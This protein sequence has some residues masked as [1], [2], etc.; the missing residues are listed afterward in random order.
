MDSTR[1]LAHIKLHLRERKSRWLSVGIGFGTSELRNLRFSLDWE[2]RN[3]F[4]TGRQVKVQNVLSYEVGKFVNIIP[5]R[6][7]N[8]FMEQ[9]LNYVEPWIFR[10]PLDG[11]VYLSNKREKFYYDSDDR[12]KSYW[13]HKWGET[14]SLSR[15][16]GAHAKLWLGTEMEWIRYSDIS[17]NEL[18]DILEEEVS[19]GV[20]HSVSLVG[21]RDSR[22]NI[23]NPSRGTFERILLKYAG[24][25]LG[26][27]Y[28]FRKVLGSFSFYRSWSPTELIS[29][30]LLAGY[31]DH[32]NSST[33]VPLHERFFTGGGTTVRGYK[34]RE[35]GDPVGGNVLM[36]S[37]VEFRFSL[38]K[39]FGT[40]F[41]LDTGNIWPYWTKVDL[42]KLRVTAGTG[43]RY[44]TLIGPLRLD[45]GI[46]I[47]YREGRRIPGRFHLSIGHTF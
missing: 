38:T 19:R 37:N 34:E 47:N 22:D 10:L 12:K 25:V 29:G 4:G 14:V 7:G 30:R 27:D 36:V 26:G 23:F 3:L 46:R 8:T 45:Y 18:Q 32:P 40:V 20:T 39:K 42:A 17:L 11:S 15:D 43:V 33:E 1:L 24:G 6:F 41:F 21:E 31:V 13:R 5:H 35:I 9:K 2:N 16:F 28:T 44:Q